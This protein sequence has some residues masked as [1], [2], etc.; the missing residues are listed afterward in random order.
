MRKLPFAFVLIA[1]TVTAMT[2]VAHV[3]AA[4]SVPAALP[5]SFVADVPLPGGATRF[6]YQAVDPKQRRLYLAHLGDSSLVVFDLDAQRVLHEVPHLPSVHG[7]VVAPE[8]HLVFA[9]ATAE[10][11][12]ALI[13]DQ[14]FEVKARVPAGAY[15]NGLAY[16]PT[17][18]RVFVSNNTGRGV[19]VIDVKSARA[20]PSIDIGGG[21]GNTQYD[22]ESGRVLAA[23]HGSPVLA[24]IDPAAAQVAGRI[25]LRKVSS[26]HGLYVASKLRLA[27]AACRGAAPLLVV[28]DLSTRRQTMTLP[29]P[30]DID[31][32]AFDPGLGRLYAASETG[33][34]A[35]FAVAADRSVSETG[36]GFLGPNAHTVAVDPTT[37]HVYFPLENVSGQPVLRVMAARTAPPD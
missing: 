6:D 14:S 25:A 12:L 20:L 16:D 35:V 27:F 17:S 7:V 22:A 15:P 11:T 31:V 18:D 26:C 3:S 1:T 2:H 36:R 19:A 37:H 33:M 30:A 21:A 10:K 34:V 9:T 5:L 24:E 32:L 29:L 23:V 8:Q 4:P 28:V 13:D